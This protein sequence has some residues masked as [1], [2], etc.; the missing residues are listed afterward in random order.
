VVLFADD[1]APDPDWLVSHLRA[2]HQ[3][4]STEVA[5]LGPIEAPEGGGDTPFDRF[6]W[7]ER[8]HFD[9]ALAE[10]EL[11]ESSA[12]GFARC[13]ASNLS[14]PRASFMASGGFDE[15]FSMAAWEDVELGY[16]LTRQGVRLGFVAGARVRA[17]PSSGSILG[18]YLCCARA[19]VARRVSRAAPRAASRGAGG[20]CAR[21]PDCEA[22]AIDGCGA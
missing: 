5:F 17:L 9:F 13:Y 16:R 3:A 20:A 7:R 6:V 10:R 15:G 18:D 11:R 8:V 21:R 12:V 2:H 19:C 4:D 1:L 22:G 14:V